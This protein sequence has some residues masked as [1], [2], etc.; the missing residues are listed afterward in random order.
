[1]SFG[2]MVLNDKMKAKFDAQKNSSKVKV[3]GVKY[4][5]KK[6]LFLSCYLNNSKSY[7]AI[8]MGFA[9]MV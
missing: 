5:L 6:W 3:T 4:W 2:S 9:S 7:W 8:L 1:M